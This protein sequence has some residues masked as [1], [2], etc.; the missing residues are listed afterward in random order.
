MINQLNSTSI[1]AL[2]LYATTRLQFVRMN[3]MLR[4]LSHLQS[5]PSLHCKSLDTRGTYQNCFRSI[6]FIP[7]A[8]LTPYGTAHENF[9]IRALIFV[10]KILVF[11]HFRRFFLYGNITD[12]H[13][14]KFREQEFSPGGCSRPPSELCSTSHT[15]GGRS[16]SKEGKTLSMLP[17]APQATI[18]GTNSLRVSPEWFRPFRSSMLPRPGSCSFCGPLT[19]NHSGELSLVGLHVSSSYSIHLTRVS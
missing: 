8:I 12:F 3:H 5:N 13:I 4:P 16:A 2:T 11:V 19:S 10:F 18:R 14:E 6:S 9:R 7:Y 1:S 15:D 17:C